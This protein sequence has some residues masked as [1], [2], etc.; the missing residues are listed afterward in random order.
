MMMLMM[1]I[2]SRQQLP[3]LLCPAHRGIKRWCA[4]DVWLRSVCCAG[5][6]IGPR[7]RTERPIGRRKLAH[8]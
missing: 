1:M 7:S 6:Y 2:D 8:R 5:P 3:E 4:S